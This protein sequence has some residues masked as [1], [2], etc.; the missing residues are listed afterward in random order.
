MSDLKD[1]LVNDVTNKKTGL[2]EREEYFLDILFDKHRGN[3]RS[4]MDDAGYPSMT[5]TR[6]VTTKLNAHIAEAAKAYLS[7]NSAK[8]SI[9]LVGIINDPTTPGANTSL[10]A[11]KEVLD[12]SGIKEQESEDRTVEKNVII[13]PAKATIEIKSEE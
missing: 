10:K 11:I 9:E 8:A 12:R 13:L 7:A 5:P 2:T 4:A 6:H 3:I 1:H